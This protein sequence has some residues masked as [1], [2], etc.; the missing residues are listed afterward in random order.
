LCCEKLHYTSSGED[1]VRYGKVVVRYSNFTK[2]SGGV[3]RACKYNAKKT[4]AGLPNGLSLGSMAGI[5]E[6]V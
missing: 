4:G 3:A 6:K 5:D 1:L 2:K